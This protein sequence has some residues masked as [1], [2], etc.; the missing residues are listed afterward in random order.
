MFTLLS[1]TLKTAAYKHI[2]FDM[3]ESFII[4]FNMSDLERSYQLQKHTACQ[5]VTR[6]A[7][8]QLRLAH[9]PS[10]IYFLIICVTEKCDREM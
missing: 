10:F 5:F 4:V 9:T 2:K 6:R 7:A 3:V 1:V 8:V